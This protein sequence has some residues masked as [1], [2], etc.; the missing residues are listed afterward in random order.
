MPDDTPTDKT[1]LMESLAESQISI[2]HLAR[3]AKEAKDKKLSD[4]LTAQA[5]A[6]RQEIARLRRSLH[7]EWKAGTARLTAGAKSAQAGLEKLV[8]RVEQDKK[9]ITRATKALSLV[10]DLLALSR[11]L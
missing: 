5:R 3:L 6:L 7:E 9:L 8:A 11:R 1:Q 2:I 4:K 10:T